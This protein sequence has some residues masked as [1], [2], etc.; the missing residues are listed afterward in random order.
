MPE[1]PTH[2]TRSYQSVDPLAT[3]EGLVVDTGVL[4][5]GCGAIKGGF[6]VGKITSGGKIAPQKKTNIATAVADT[7]STTAIVVRQAAGFKTGDVCD[8][9]DGSDNSSELFSDKTI[10]SVNYDTNTITFTAAL[11]SGVLAVEDWIRLKTV[12]GAEAA[13]GVVLDNIFTDTATGTIL[14]DQTVTV[15][16]RGTLLKAQIP[17]ATQPL[18]NLATELVSRIG[19]IASQFYILD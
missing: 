17:Q 12:D 9:V 3:R 16:I 2:T 15:A 14:K 10:S 7:V 4:A 1:V 6:T 8:I 5:A 19:G 13:V 18:H 11:G